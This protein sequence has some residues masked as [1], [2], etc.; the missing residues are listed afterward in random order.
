MHFACAAAPTEHQIDLGA[1]QVTAHTIE[2]NSSSF[3]QFVATLEPELVIFDRFVTEEQFGWRVA[4]SCS[5]AMRILDTEDLHSL[6]YAREKILKKAQ[7]NNQECGP[8]LAQSQEIFQ[9]MREDELVMREVAAIFRCDL[10][11]MISEF[12]ID[13]L[14]R[15]FSVPASLLLHVPFMVECSARSTPT[16]AEREHFVSIGNFRHA[17]NWDA[18]LWLKQD[19]WPLLRRRCPSAQL[20]IY[21]AYPPKKATQLTNPKERFLVKGW[22]DDALQVVENAKVLLAPLRFGAGIKGKIVD[23]MR[24]STPSVVTSIAAESMAGDCAWPGIVADTKESFVDAAAQ[25]YQNESHWLLAS[26]ACLPLLCSRY[27][28]AMR[29]EELMSIV[30]ARLQS[31]ER[32]RRNNFLGG[33]FQYHSARSTEFMSRWIEVKSRIN[34]Q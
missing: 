2:L 3:N 12:E 22:A 16:F 34:A 10:S 32:F 30:C 6:R 27:D 24:T 31:L 15:F 23:A 1:M 21:G 8:V 28:F 14:T 20:H 9:V 7:K 13:L 26:Q 33:M 25:I 19:L 5:G 18:V 11:L 4:E 17:P 29:S